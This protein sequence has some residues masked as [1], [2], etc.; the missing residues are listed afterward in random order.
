LESNNLRSLANK[1]LVEIL[2]AIAVVFSL[3][4]VGFE[5]RQSNAIATRDARSQPIA[6]LV[7]IERLAIENPLHASL[8]VKLS[9]QDP[10]LSAQEYEHAR[11]FSQLLISFWASID[12]ARDSGFL[13]DQTF[14]SYSEHADSVFE[15]YPGMKPIVKRR[16]Q[17]WGI[18]PEYS[19]IY[20]RVYQHFEPA[21]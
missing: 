6:Q 2:S 17:E 3:I 10:R 16:L 20:T 21:Q 7:E 8:L 18:G 19:E 13:P 4:F 9:A 5:L 12:T 11:A 15:R 1:Q 14:E